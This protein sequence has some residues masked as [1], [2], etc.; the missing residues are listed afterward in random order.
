MTCET[1]P[2]GGHHER[3][4][5]W[6]MKKLLVAGVCALLA[7]LPAG[8]AAAQAPVSYRIIFD[9]GAILREADLDFEVLRLGEDVG[10]AAEI[11]LY[12]LDSLDFADIQVGNG[13]RLVLGGASRPY[14]IYSS[15]IMAGLPCAQLPFYAQMYAVYTRLP[16]LVISY[17]GSAP[18]ACVMVAALSSVVHQSG[19]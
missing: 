14:V 13:L 10:R 4:W 5:G 7:W 12:N 9:S 8:A 19:L 11:R 2:A 18:G 6:T 16:G 17:E 1:P 15:Y 3:G